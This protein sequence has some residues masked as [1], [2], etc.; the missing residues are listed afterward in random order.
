MARYCLKV[1]LTTEGNFY[2]EANSKE[3][4]ENILYNTPFLST[5][6]TNKY[7]PLDYKKE[8]TYWYANKENK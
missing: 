1:K 7:F 2:V 5:E 8:I 4:A 3:E 6:I